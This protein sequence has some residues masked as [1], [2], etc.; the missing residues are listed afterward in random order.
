MSGNRFSFKHAWNAFI[1]KS[2]GVSL[3]H[4]SDLVNWND[5]GAVDPTTASKITTVWQCVRVTSDAI[6]STPLEVYR[7][8]S[9]GGRKLVMDHPLWKLLHDSPAPGMSSFV[10]RQLLQRYLELRGNSYCFKV[11]SRRRIVALIPIHPDRV[12]VYIALDGTKRF[13]VYNKNGTVSDFGSDEIWHMLGCSTDDGM[14][15]LSPIDELRNLFETAKAA[16]RYANKAMK[17]DGATG[18]VFKFLGKLKPETREAMKKDWAEN[19]AG[20]ENAGKPL[21]LEEGGEATR[22]NL[23]MAQM[24]FLEQRKFNRSEIAAVFRVPMHMV[25]DL[26]RATFSNIE[27]QSLE[28]KAYTIRPWARRWEASL[29]TDV[30]SWYNEDDVFVAFDLDD[31]EVIDINTRYEAHASSI[32]AGWKTRNEVRET[33]NYNPL[34]GLDKPLEPTN[35]KRPGEGG[36]NPNDPT[37]KN[38]GK[39]DPSNS[40]PPKK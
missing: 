39:P 14:I 8:M 26:E 33:E 15:G 13:K 7:R 3:S 32:I 38:P 4:P 19:H 30:V 18:V 10:W 40:E 29:L 28:F 22:L 11:M 23:T 36:G 27:H 12:Q 9:N 21:L 25:G 1:G 5:S 2:Q 35:M 20:G 24:Q 34:P 31:L 16:E 6:A 17:N 37:S